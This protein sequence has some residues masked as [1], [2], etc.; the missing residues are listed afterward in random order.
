MKTPSLA[1]EGAVRDGGRLQRSSDAQILIGRTR[2]A[3][4]LG[5]GRGC[6]SSGH[7]VRAGAGSPPLDLQRQGAARP[8][9]PAR[10]ARPV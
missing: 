2:L 1:V 3:A 6:R 10:K 9:A 5:S 8:S 7:R 4:C